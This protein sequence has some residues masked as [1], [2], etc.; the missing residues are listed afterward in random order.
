MTP[1]ARATG[2]VNTTFFRPSSASPSRVIHVG[3]N[4]DAA[5]VSNTL[6]SSFLHM[7]S[8]I[9]GP[10]PRRFA[11]GTAAAFVVGGGG[12]TRAAIYALSRLSLS[13]IFIVNR[14]PTETTQVIDSFPDIDV[15]PLRTP[16]QSRQEMEDLLERGARLVCGVGAIPCE[17]PTSE[18]ETLVYDVATEVFALAG[19]EST[20]SAGRPRDEEETFLAL[21]TKPVFVGA[22]V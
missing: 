20:A 19:A 3:T 14:D 8:P 16:E 11:P 22:S 7:P 12:A 5:A 18:A 17:P 4:T 2:C 21:P 10:A 15:R 1:E 9:L 6:L 13:P